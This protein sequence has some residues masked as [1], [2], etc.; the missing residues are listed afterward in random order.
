MGSSSY[1]VDGDF[2]ILS[3][4]QSSETAKND[5]NDELHESA[6]DTETSVF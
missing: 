5:K 4:T 1:E 2:I 6:I 3:L